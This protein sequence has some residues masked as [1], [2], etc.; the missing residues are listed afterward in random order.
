MSENLK[1]KTIK[2]RKEVMDNNLTNLENDIN[3]LVEKKD[4][5]ESELVEKY[6]DYNDKVFGNGEGKTKENKL[7]I[8]SDIKDLQE[9]V[10]H[11]YLEV[12]DE[13]EGIKEKIEEFKSNAESI[14]NNLVKIEV[15]Y[16]QIF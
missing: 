1:I 5:I 4:K 3:S 11:Y 12:F 7:S 2:N 15:H 8:L 10:N 6:T 16:L 13:D 14:K 9:K